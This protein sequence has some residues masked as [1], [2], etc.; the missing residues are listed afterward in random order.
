MNHKT[1]FFITMLFGFLATSSCVKRADVPNDPKEI[2]KKYIEMSF[3]IEKASDRSMLE[4]FLTGDAKARLKVWSD[5]QFEEAFVKTKRKD[6]KLQIRE[7]RK[8]GDAETSITYEIS[9]RD[10]KN[11]QRSKV[12]NR[13]L[14]IFTRESE[15]WLIKDC[16]NIKQLVEYQNE[17]ALP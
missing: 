9:Y 6:P 1:G 8:T 12:T 16:K 13:K 4:E 14:C 15:R 7:V 17:M 2:L 11:G 3:K 10:E 5:D